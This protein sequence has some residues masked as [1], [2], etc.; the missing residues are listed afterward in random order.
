MNKKKLICALSLVG[1]M[2]VACQKPGSSES[3][4]GPTSNPPASTPSTNPGTEIPEATFNGNL[5]ETKLFSYA[6]VITTSMYK[7]TGRT[8]EIFIGEGEGGA[9]LG[10]EQYYGYKQQ[11]SSSTCSLY[12]DVM[13]C[14]YKDVTEKRKD[15]MDLSSETYEETVKSVN[16][17]HLEERTEGTFYHGCE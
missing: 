1:M 10:F 16:Q 11:T 3:D 9:E 13:E 7:A 6:N 17:V 8:G 12:S 4:T 5:G 15:P 2:L 14:Q